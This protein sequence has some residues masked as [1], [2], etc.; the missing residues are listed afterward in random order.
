MNIPELKEELKKRVQPLLGN[1]GALVERL[2]SALAKKFP[3]GNGK[4]P[5]PKKSDKSKRW[6][7]VRWFPDIAYWKVPKPKNET[8]DDPN[9]ATFKNPRAPTIPEEDA[10]YVP[11]KHDFDTHIERPVFT[12]PYQKIMTLIPILNSRSLQV[13]NML[14]V[15]VHHYHFVREFRRS[16]E[17]TKW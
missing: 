15:L 11:T 3:V 8:V 2:L 16:E 7:G 9:N 5:K 10:K 12:G 1:N 4:K 6:G 14:D 13:S 17:R